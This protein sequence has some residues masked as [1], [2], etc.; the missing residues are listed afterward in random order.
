MTVREEVRGQGR[1]ATEEERERVR[2]GMISEGREG[3]RGEGERRE[4]PR[5]QV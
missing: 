2:A 5:K 1:M 3:E 4:G